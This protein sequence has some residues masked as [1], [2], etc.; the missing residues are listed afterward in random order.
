[1]HRVE[2]DKAV[3]AMR[4]SRG[5]VLIEVSGTDRV[6]NAA[7]VSGVPG[8]EVQEFVNEWLDL[9]RDLRGFYGLLRSDPDMSF[10]A[11]RFRGFHIVGIPD[12]FE[13]LVWCFIGQQINLTFAYTLKRRL[14]ER[15]GEPV[16]FGDRTYWLFPTPERL[17]SV[18]TDELRAL[19]FTTRKAEFIVGLSRQFASGTI[20]KQKLLEKGSEDDMMAWLLGFRGIG[21]WTANYALMKSVRAMNRVPFGDAGLHQALAR[22]KGVHK[23]SASQLERILQP[24]DGWKTYLVFYLWRSLREMA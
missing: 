13:C 23:P 6:L 15:F 11:R 10:L 1:M 16:P 20:T 8:P 12:L 19:Q 24:F 2:G 17:S 14:V 9:S 18:S 21:P 22:Y 3:R 4:S 5:P 7:V